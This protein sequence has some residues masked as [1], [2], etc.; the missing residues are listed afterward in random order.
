MLGSICVLLWSFIS[1]DT[2]ALWEVSEFV[3]FSP[4][5]AI[6]ILLFL[7]A[8]IGSQACSRYFCVIVTTKV[9][10]F[11]KV[12]PII[13]HLFLQAGKDRNKTGLADTTVNSQSLET[14]Y[15]IYSACLLTTCL[16]A[17]SSSFRVWLINR[18]NWLKTAG[19]TIRTPTITSSKQINV[20][21]SLFVDVLY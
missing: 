7:W 12:R 13:N 6:T 21:R 14:S 2:T 1:L 11:F 3:S 20:T 10:E 19:P 16:K 9:K 4:I 17:Q 18:V 15:S 8:K 5:V